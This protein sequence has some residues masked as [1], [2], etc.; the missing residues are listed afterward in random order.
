LCL[1]NCEDVDLQVL[2]IRIVQ[3]IVVAYEGGTTI[4][5]ASNSKLLSCVENSMASTHMLYILYMPFVVLIAAV[6][7]Q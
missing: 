5:C 2:W 7:S 3:V 1:K 6:G 4:V